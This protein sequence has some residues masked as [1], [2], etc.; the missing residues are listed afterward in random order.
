MARRRRPTLGE[1]DSLQ[2]RYDAVVATVHRVVLERNDAIKQL[3][4]IK[5]NAR[6]DLTVAGNRISALESRIEEIT[7]ID[8]SEFLSILWRG[9]T[10]RG[11]KRN[12]P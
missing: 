10:F 4:A 12:G 1:L 2:R 6:W 8:T 5:L 3:D 9:L 11:W 7:P